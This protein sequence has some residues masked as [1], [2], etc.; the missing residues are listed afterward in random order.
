MHIYALY[1]VCLINV[2]R[3]KN[4]QRIFMESRERSKLYVCNCFIYHLLFL[5]IFA[6]VESPIKLNKWPS[7]CLNFHFFLLCSLSCVCVWVSF[8]FGVAYIKCA[9]CH[10]CLLL[11]DMHRAK[12]RVRHKTACCSRICACISLDVF[13]RRVV[14]VVVHCNGCLQKIW[15]HKANEP[16]NCYLAICIC[17]LLMRHISSRRLWIPCHCPFSL[18]TVFTSCYLFLRS[19]SFALSLY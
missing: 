7:K 12:E 9:L 16:E 8:S 18:E 19:Q 6:G 17:I 13:F 15:H 3:G 14:V 4:S 2:G 11:L 1:R 5:I 10:C